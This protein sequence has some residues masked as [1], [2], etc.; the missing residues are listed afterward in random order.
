MVM[1]MSQSDRQE[2]EGKAVIWSSPRL[3]SRESLSDVLSPRH[4]LCKLVQK[5][6]RATTKVLQV[7]HEIP[8]FWTP[9]RS[10]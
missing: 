1:S 10:V 3:S 4:F 2:G 7:Y 9:H 5:K 6:E 8:R